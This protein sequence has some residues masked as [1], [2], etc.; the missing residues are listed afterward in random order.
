MAEM[1]IMLTELRPAVMNDINFA[2]LLRLLSDSF[3]GRTNIPVS[4]NSVGSFQF[5][6]DV[7]V[8]LY[9]ICQESLNNVAKHADADQVMI[10]L[11][12]KEDF[13]ELSVRDNGC[14]FD[15]NKIPNGRMGLGIMKERA[16]EV[17][18]ELVI[19]S[20]PG[21]GTEVDLLWRQ[22]AARR[23]M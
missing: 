8:A 19:R 11:Q 6:T 16:E 15:L 23:A 14:G 1:R 12:N 13:I 4:V 17:G 2:D 21:Q 10:Y 18:A 20:S 9:R 5:P 22:E 3:T 7:Q